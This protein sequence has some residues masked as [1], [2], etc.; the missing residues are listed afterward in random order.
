M[1]GMIDTTKATQ[2]IW[3]VRL[4]ASTKSFPSPCRKNEIKLT[5]PYRTVI[6]ICLM[7]AFGEFTSLMRS[8]LIVYSASFITRA[9]GFP[10][11]YVFMGC[12]NS[13][14]FCVSFFACETM[15]LA[16]ENVNELYGERINPWES[17]D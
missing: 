14:S 13:L 11:G 15:G 1:T 16:L 2:L 10:Y 9:I 17:G 6:C 7:F 5:I 4:E 8:F 12:P 3:L